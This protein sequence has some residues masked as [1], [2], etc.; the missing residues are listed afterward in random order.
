ML[1]CPSAGRGAVVDHD[2]TGAADPLPA[3][4]VEGNRLLTLVGE[5]VVEDVEHLEK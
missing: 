1:Q 5:S 4:V 2:T 3:V